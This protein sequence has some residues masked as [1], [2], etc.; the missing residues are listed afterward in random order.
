MSARA[1]SD[2]IRAL[3]KEKLSAKVSLSIAISVEVAFTE[4]QKAKKKENIWAK[5]I[6]VSSAKCLPKSNTKGEESHRFYCKT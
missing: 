2:E 6:V 1:I 3:V 4:F 5:K